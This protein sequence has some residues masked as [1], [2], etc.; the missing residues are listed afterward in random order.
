[1]QGIFKFIIPALFIGMTSC[2]N[3]NDQGKVAD[4]E[5][6]KP[7][8]EQT[9]PIDPVAPSDESKQE[10]AAQTETAKEA[11]KTVEKPET[12]VKTIKASLPETPK[13][14]NEKPEK[15]K[16][17]KEE[18]VEVKEEP[19]DEVNEE[20]KEEEPV[21]PAAPTHQNWDK[22]LRKYVT[23]SGKVNYKGFKADQAALQA[24]LD[25]LASNPI[26]SSWTRNEKMAYWINAYNAFTIKLIVDNYPTQSITKLHG[27]KPWDVKWIKLGD[28]TYTLNNIENDILRPQ[29]KDAR[30]HFAVNCAALSCP[31][32]INKAW[33]AQNLKSTLNAQA[34]KFINNTKYNT[35]T[36]DK[37][38]ISKIFEWYA[39]DFGSSIIDYLNKYSNTKINPNATV[40]YME[41]NWGL[42]E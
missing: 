40:E 15:P 2:S 16:V 29:Y 5:P 9:T 35:I 7:V 41:Y 4:Q 24:Y 6:T 14:I 20:P 19:K 3:P 12:P 36:A 39:V 23:A 38:V 8:I 21:I 33:T 37:V 34:K 28:K 30:I 31:P 1:M 11:P 18:K 26:Q 17:V 32:I 27:G 13:K 22:L 25:E 42:N 10:I